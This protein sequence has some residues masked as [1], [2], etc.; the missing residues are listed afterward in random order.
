MPFRDLLGCFAMLLTIS[1]PTA[2]VQASESDSA[3]AATTASEPTRI[4]IAMRSVV[5]I[6]YGDEEDDPDGSGFVAHASG[7]IVTNTHVV[8]R[9]RGDTV[10]IAFVDGRTYVGTV[11]GRDPRTDLAVVK[12]TPETPLVP[13]KLAASS[14]AGLGTRVYALGSPMGKRFSVTSGIISGYDRAYDAAWPVDFLQHDAALNPGN[15]GGPLI[16]EQGQ[17]L[18]VNTATPPETLFDMGI[19]LAVPAELV[20]RI[21]PELVAS[22][23]VSRGAL[24]VKVSSADTEIAAA[25]GAPGTKG[26][27]VDEVL[28][29]SA[30][31][32]AGLQTGD[33]IVKLGERRLL[34][35]RDLSLALLDSRPGEIRTL[36]V[37]R[38]GNTI[39]Q[40]IVLGPDDPDAG[41][42]GRAASL[43]LDPVAPT[44]DS[45]AFGLVFEERA[46]RIVIAAVTEGS[47]AQLYGL[48]EGDV[49]LA[50]NGNPAGGIGSLRTRIKF[51]D[52]EV[53]VLR[54]AREGMGVFHVALPLTADVAAARRPGQQK[55]FPQG[56]L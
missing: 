43:T 35:A 3:T 25:L 1:V 7:Y 12:I 36:T 54:F 6:S 52:G 47:I 55:R 23:A 30:A 48:Y 8:P 41:E 14:R 22:G 13:L 39:E 2:P 5:T 11:V 29:G 21:V 53:A 24:G 10:R 18:G 42:R 38:G 40:D 46:G 28:P 50:L 17:V 16:D 44:E 9:R 19:G 32:S 4:E 31:Q 37:V 26:L 27:L 49:L 51:L 45:P 15:S 56:P 20:A 33:I 34:L